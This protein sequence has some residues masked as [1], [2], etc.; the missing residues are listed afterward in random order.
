MSGYLNKV[1]KPH[2]MS[3][4]IKDKKLLKNMNLFRIR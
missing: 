4:A 2:C 3:F 1:E